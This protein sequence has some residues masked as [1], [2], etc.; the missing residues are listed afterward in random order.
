MAKL[1]IIIPIFT[2]FPTLPIF[3]FILLP[4]HCSFFRFQPICGLRHR[5]AAA[6]NTSC[7]PS[8]FLLPKI[9]IFAHPFFPHP[10][11]KN[12]QPHLLVLHCL[13]CSNYNHPSIACLVALMMALIMHFTF[14]KLDK[15]THF[16]PKIYGC[17]HQKFFII[18]KTP[19]LY[20]I[21]PFL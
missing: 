19:F 16:S 3:L 8:T 21:L 14:E 5:F 15:F 12:W 2:T 7:R 18:S 11:A 10:A 4:P 17:H 20:L 1:C 9:H 13:L 6:L